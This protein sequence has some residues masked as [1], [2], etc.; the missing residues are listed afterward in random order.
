MLTFAVDTAIKFLGIPKNSQLFL[1]TIRFLDATTTELD[2]FGTN[3][4]NFSFEPKWKELSSIPSVAVPTRE[5]RTI[6]ATMSGTAFQ[7]VPFIYQ[8]NVFAVDDMGLHS[9]LLASSVQRR[10]YEMVGETKNR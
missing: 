10:A 4:W 1:L 7:P 9:Y 6:P 8:K 2:C 5:L 3:R